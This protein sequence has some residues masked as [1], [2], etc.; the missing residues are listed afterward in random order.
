M[1]HRTIPSLTI[2]NVVNNSAGTESPSTT[3]H[4]IRGEKHQQQRKR[5]ISNITN[6]NMTVTVK[7][8]RP[9][10]VARE[11]MHQV[12]NMEK[13]LASTREKLTEREQEL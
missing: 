3:A 5:N 2:N 4:K 6:S 7:G 11:A 13:I 12:S 1:D 8:K 9:Y 10:L